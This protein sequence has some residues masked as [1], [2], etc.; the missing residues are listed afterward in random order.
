MAALIVQIPLGRVAHWRLRDDG[1]VEI[2][3]L[4]LL[5]LPNARARANWDRGTA[6]GESQ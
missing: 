3:M 6:I 5:T 2:E 1:V 4:R